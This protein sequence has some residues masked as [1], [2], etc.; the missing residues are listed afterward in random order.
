M[1]T[2]A[3]LNDLNDAHLLKSM[4]EAEG[5]PVFIPDEN[6]IQ[7]DWLLLNAIGG[8]RLQTTADHTDDAAKII[9]IF[10]KN[11]KQPLELSCPHC[12]GGNIYAEKVFRNWALTVLVAFGVPLPWS[13]RLACRDCGCQWK[14]K[15]L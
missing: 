10:R 4:L 6:T 15:G 1:Q 14:R 7:M 2:I 5:I 9:E 13:H 8:V 12:G 3:V 11:Q